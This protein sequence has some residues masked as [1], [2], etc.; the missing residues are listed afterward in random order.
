MPW[1]QRKNARIT[2]IESGEEQ[3]FGSSNL[4][5]NERPAQ[6]SWVPPQPPPV[7]IPEAATAIRQPKKALSQTESI[8]DDPLLARSG[9]TTDELERITKFSE[10]G[11]SV[12]VNSGS[13]DPLSTDLPNGENGSYLEA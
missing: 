4:P 8:T 5:S 6:R 9:D 10:T 2:E 11:G 13:S 1:W 7:V 12:E 3:K